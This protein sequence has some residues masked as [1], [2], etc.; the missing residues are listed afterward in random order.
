[1]KCF[2]NKCSP[3]TSLNNDVFEFENIELYEAS[4][5]PK[6]GWIHSCIICGSFTSRTIL[7]DKTQYLNKNYNF[8][9]YVCNSCNGK[10]SDNIKHYILF[11]KKASNMIRQHKIR[12]FPVNQPQEVLHAALPDT[13]I[14]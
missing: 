9:M 11:S 1:M 13:S 7:F 5:M 4:H 8:N 10:I 2:N 14:S 6:K 12:H 3:I